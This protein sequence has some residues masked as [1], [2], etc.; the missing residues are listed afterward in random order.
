MKQ[1]YSQG[2]NNGEIKITI[3]ARAKRKKGSW[4]IETGKHLSAKL[5]IYFRCFVFTVSY[6]LIYGCYFPA[7]C[8]STPFFPPL[9]E[10]HRKGLHPTRAVIQYFSVLER[11]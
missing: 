11:M 5:R 8:F 7:T 3:F 1:K 6:F 9:Q 4:K 2:T 10:K